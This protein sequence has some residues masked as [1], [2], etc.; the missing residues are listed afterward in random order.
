MGTGPPWIPGEGFSR[1]GSRST[2]RG[3]TLVT[4]PWIPYPVHFPL[5]FRAE[6]PNMNPPT[7]ASGTQNLTVLSEELT[8]APPG[9][10]VLGKASW[11]S[12]LP[13][14]IHGI[15]TRWGMDE[16]RGD[17]FDLRLR[18][19]AAADEVLGRWDALQALADTSAVVHARQLHG[20]TVRVHGE[21]PPGLLLAP[22]CD[23]HATREPDV[24]LTVSLADCV[25]IFVVD[26]RARLVALLHAG[27]RG[28][29]QGILEEGLQ[30]LEDHFGAGRE[31]LQVHLGPAIG[32]ASYEVGPEVHEAL[33]LPV[34]SGPSSLDLRAVLARRA[35]QAG[36]SPDN[37]SI[38]RR[39]TRTDPLLFSHRGGDQGRHVAFLGI[40]D[41]PGGAE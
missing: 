12:T 31:G 33:G 11:S 28:T 15:T 16:E 3:F 13:W 2:F 14:L 24:L 5:R 40:R 17:L 21:L 19:P 27:W 26:P 18:G 35:L 20:S 37:L 7:A 23:G 29:A 39:D 9:P 34:P 1:S 25:P 4:T 30:T 36:I 22:P 41:R 32:E 6:L 38:S 8:A 10:P